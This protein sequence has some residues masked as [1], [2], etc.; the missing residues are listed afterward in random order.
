MPGRDIAKSPSVVMVTERKSIIGEWRVYTSGFYIRARFSQAV[1]F[2]NDEAGTTGNP[3]KPG[4]C[5]GF[6][7]IWIV[8]FTHAIVM[9]VRYKGAPERGNLIIMKTNV[10]TGDGAAAKPA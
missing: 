6:I 1:A 4:L 10:P 3:L 2:I 5:G 8:P 7:R 9:A